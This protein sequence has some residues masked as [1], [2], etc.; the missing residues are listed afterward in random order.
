MPGAGRKEI[1]F[2]AIIEGDLIEKGGYLEGNPAEFN[3]EFALSG[4][5]FVR[6]VETTQPEVW[7]QLAREHGAKRNEG[8]FDALVRALAT[9]GTLDVLRHG[10]KFFGKT[11]QAAFFKPAHGMNPDLEKQSAGNR[12]V[13]TRQVKFNPDGEDSVD[14]LLSVNGLPVATLELKNPLSGQ[15]VEH[16]KKQYQGRDARLLLF[17]FKTRALVHFAVD[18]DEV[19]M[20]TRLAGKETFFLPLNRGNNG[21]KGNPAVEGAGYRTGY[22]WREILERE[23]LLDLLARFIHLLVEEETVNGKK[24]TKESLIFP[25]YHQLDVVRR[26]VASAREEGSGH[27]YLVQHSA[28][29]GKSNSIAWVA[30]RLA[31]LHDTQDKKVFDSVV[32]VTD[33]LILDKQLQNTI[34]QF[35]H[36][37]G[38]VERIEKDSTQLA[39]ALERGTPI[40]ITTLQKFPFVADKVA[41]LPSR[42]YAVIVDEAHSSQSGEAADRLRQ[43]LAAPAA[44]AQDP[45]EPTHEDELAK[46][47][48]SHGRQKNLSFFAFTATPKAKT[49]ELFGGKGPDG[50]P[51]P[52]H[53]YSM[54]QAIEE[55]FI[56][57]VLRNYTTYR[58]YFKLVKAAEASDPD[59]KKREATKALARAMTLHPTE[60]GRKTEVIVEHFRQ[61]IRKKLG[62]NGKALV[63]TRS[64]LHAVKFKQAFDAY[65]KEK[66][67]SDLRSLVAFSG[68]VKDPDTEQELTEVGMNGGITELGLPEKFKTEDYQ[69]LI[70]ANKYQTG[71][72]EP[73][74]CAMYVDKRLAG[75]QAVQTLSRLNRMYPGKAETFVLDF[76]NEADEIRVSFQPY[77][78]QTTVSETAD[79]HLLEQLRHALDDAQIWHMEEVEAF[80]KV[81]YRPRQKLTDRESEELYRHLG[82]AKDRWI[83]VKDE[84]AR[85]KWRGTLDAFVRLYSFMCQ[86]LP[87]TDRDLEIRATF[88]RYLLKRLPV[89]VREVLKLDG[90]VDLHSY[91]LARIAEADIE[92][93]KS[94]GGSVKGVTAAGTRKA[95]D[96]KVPLHEIIALLNERFGT[97]FTTADQ[98][99]FDAVVEDGKSD[100]KIKAQALANPFE[101]FALATRDKIEG[102]MIDRMDRNQEIVTKFL[103]E[104]DFKKLVSQLVAKRIYDE[105]RRAAGA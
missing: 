74:L 53:L 61:H 104:P 73:L 59:V 103:D 102:L 45:E 18:P 56:L 58:S 20:T 81:F 64:R 88:G 32:V 12:V 10:F 44:E 68:T 34:Y 55:G 9:R 43:V 99:L 1:N 76:V 37:Q 96:E 72:D 30:H 13:V 5:D 97:D 83:A 16:A 67:Y 49:L 23:S 24:I 71:F 36:K 14:M 82:P 21:G 57:D 101:S 65:V 75:V 39:K 29:S 28:G 91:R 6:F 47:L 40:I 69:V 70:A 79:P 98:L 66:G 35:E 19:F 17:S 84:D 93:T 89:G 38:V 54:R 27:H 80:A 95:K 94:L 22:L 2:E 51:A 7:T 26:L 15:T 90:E 87:W 77:Y 33:R 8:V 62:G 4:P 31:S 52:F 41:A 46:V 78:E 48:A 50:K 42:R 86:V 85:E 63:V 92:L 11:I 25:R 105:L 100:D 60:I 3:A